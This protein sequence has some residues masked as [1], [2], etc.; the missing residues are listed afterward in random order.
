MLCV[1]YDFV[2]ILCNRVV[3]L[4]GCNYSKHAIFQTRKRMADIKN[5]QC[6]KFFSYL[7]QKKNKLW[8]KELLFICTF[9]RQTNIFTLALFVRCASNLGK[10]KLELV[11]LP[12][13]TD[14]RSRMSH[15]ATNFVSYARGFW[16]PC[17]RNEDQGKRMRTGTNDVSRSY[18]KRYL[19]LYG[20][21]GV[22]CSF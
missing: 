11:I 4:G 18:K 7:C 21:R 1:Y 17:Q 19:F 14:R 16:R 8:A 5:M 20:R 22:N 13:G 2:L 6:V 12:S 15:I 9:W 3:V 10:R